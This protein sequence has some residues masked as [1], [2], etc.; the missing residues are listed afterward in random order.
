MIF[1]ANRGNVSSWDILTQKYLNTTSYWSGSCY[2]LFPFLYHVPAPI[3]L[4]RRALSARW[5]WKRGSVD[6]THHWSTV[7]CPDVRPWLLCPAPQTGDW[8]TTHTHTHT[9]NVWIGMLTNVFLQREATGIIVYVINIWQSNT[10][11]IILYHKQGTVMAIPLN[12]NKTIYLTIPL[13]SF[14]LSIS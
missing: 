3:G 5:L 8:L 7:C 10:I 11:L 9:V 4:A 12:S 14:S 1:F 13:R 2:S 6:L